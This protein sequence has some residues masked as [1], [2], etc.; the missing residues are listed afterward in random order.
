MKILSKVVSVSTL[1]L[2]LCASGWMFAQEQHEDAKPNDESR[3]AASKPAHDEKAKPAHEDKRGEAKPQE[4]HETGK[5]PEQTEDK[6]MHQE[7]TKQGDRNEHSNQTQMR[8]QGSD[9]R[10][11]GRIPE[12]KFKSNFG[13]QH[14]FKVSRP[15]VVGGQ[16]QFQY[17]GY[18]FNIIGAWPGD[19]SYDDPVYVDYIN[20]EYFLFDLAH[21][22]VSVAVVVVM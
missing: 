7:N 12:D 9:H 17:G 21:P 14:T 3:P 20:G 19:W 18:S 1:S 4:Q 8:A 5:V 10:G 15:T 16:P 13:R 2:F 6:S 22:G 11:G